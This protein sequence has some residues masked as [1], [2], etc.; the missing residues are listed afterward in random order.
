MASPSLRQ[1]AHELGISHTTVSEALRGSPRV[2]A[3]TR[4]KI[5]KAANELGYQRN[6]LAGALMSEMRRSRA[7]TFRGVL[8]V[9]D[10]DGG[11]GRPAG[12]ARYHA[13]LTK[14]ATK[15]AEELGFKADVFS[16]GNGG[17][18]LE[19][20]DTILQ[21]RGIRGIFLLPVRETPDLSRLGWSHFSG[22]YADYVIERPGLHAVCPDHYRAML[23]ALDR[24]QA[25]GY[26]RPG[27]VMSSHHDKR[28]LHRWEAAYHA[29]QTHHDGMTRLPPLL[30]SEPNQADF[31]RWFRTVKCDVVLAHN[32]EVML[33]MRAAG[34]KVPET[35]GFC[36][37]N[38]LN[39][40][41]PCA[42]LDLHP[43]LLGARGVELLV[44][45]VL[46]NEVGAPDMPMTT[47]LPAGWVDGPSVRL[48]A[49]KAGR[50]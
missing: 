44:S 46:C 21:S 5:L 16:V 41:K 9:L 37:L 23:T 49:K 6:P 1:L 8:A 34:A 42:G 17:L 48:H 13:E 30:M 2:K 11:E 31:T 3:E 36:C 50:A 47:V 20:L 22:I 43:Q 12:P 19:R 32:P 39:S 45:Q 35:H 38:V 24:L 28:L 29:Y 33:W 27:L 10:L 15:R 18:S 40:D 25:L 7:G 14:G 26:K 4:T